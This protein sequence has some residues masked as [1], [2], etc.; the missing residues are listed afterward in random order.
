[1]KKRFVILDRDGTI[2]FD[3]DHLTKVSEVELIPNVTSA[4]RKLND[5]GLGI[6]MLTNQT[7]VGNKHISLNELNVIHKRILK[8]L[9]NEGAIIDGIYFC[10]HK[11]EDNCSCRKPKIGLIKQALKDYDFE[12]KQSF[13]IGDNKSDIELGKNIGATTILVRTGYGRQMEKAIDPDYV[14]DNLEAVLPII[15]ASSKPRV[16]RPGMQAK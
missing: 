6:I 9:R 8:L 10:P 4:I 3:K 13:V 12:P 2:I 1:M 5:L 15:T 14:V 16:F 7:V 11:V